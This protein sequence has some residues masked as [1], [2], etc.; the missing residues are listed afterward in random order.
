MKNYNFDQIIPRENTSC[1]KYD[2]RQSI[3]GNDKVIPM[4]VADMDFP[5][6]DFILEAL[7]KRIKHPIL[8]YTIR[9]EAFNEA[10][11]WWNLKRHD[12]IVKPEFISICAG[13]VSGLNHAIQAYTDPRDKIIIQT[14]V[15]HPF[16]STIKNNGREIVQNPLIERNMRYSID[17]NHLEE[18]AKKGAK[19]IIISNPH[20]PVGRVWTKEELIKLGDICC[21]YKILVVSDEIHSDLIIKPNKHIPF[22]S[23]S[24]Q[25]AFS[26][27][28][29]AST[30][31]TFNLAGL[32]TG[33]AIISN[34]ELLNKY[35]Q[36]LEATGA[37]MGNIFGYEAV[38]AA[39][40]TNGELWL[41]EVMNYIKENARLVE[42]FLANNLPKI[43]LS[44]L[45]GTY[46]LWLDFRGFG[47]ND[48][49]IND[50]LINRAGV[51]LNKGSVFGEQGINFQRMNIACSRKIVEE[52]LEHMHSVFKDI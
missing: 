40:T 34:P 21:K 12:W 4:W 44:K 49:I 48:D 28:T 26:S 52:A 11:V 35:N 25:F 3:F 10:I 15:Y 30:S 7:A 50:L 45:E 6:P 31:K 47:L 22:A 43:K 13:V 38:K 2:L 36:A 14:P 8:G 33:H 1:V 16:F 39:Y 9:D 23:L 20:N 51:G 17:F 19:M 18:I 27:V 32:F 5:T 46:L 41:D 37:G 42:E 29:F 24:E